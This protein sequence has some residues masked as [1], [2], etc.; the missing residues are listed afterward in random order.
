MNTIRKHPITTIVIIALALASGVVI[1]RIAT[2]K[3]ITALESTGTQSIALLKLEDYREQNAKV[4]TVG[5]VEALEQVEL[6][7]QLAE[8]I[9]QVHIDIGSKVTKS[10][11]LITLE[12]NELQARLRDRKSVV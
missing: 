6:R 7:S 5:V 11:A 2:T 9:K 10:Q 3:S 12:N 4:S 1:H 8:Y